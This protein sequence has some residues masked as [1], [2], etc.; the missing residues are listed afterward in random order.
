MTQINI[1]YKNT[2]IEIARLYIYKRMKQ[3]KL[4]ILS[5][6]IFMSSSEFSNYE[7]YLFTYLR[8]YVHLYFNPILFSH[9]FQ[10]LRWTNIQM[11]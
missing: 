8:T 2:F 4:G 9:I 5:N 10:I 1:K 6:V 11:E 3:K 7:P